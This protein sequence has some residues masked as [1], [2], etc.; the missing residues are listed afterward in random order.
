MAGGDKVGDD[1]RTGMAGA[2]GNKN[3]HMRSLMGSASNDSAT[4][5]G[6]EIMLGFSLV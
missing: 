6:V 1:V 4:A 3:V 5:S 2:A